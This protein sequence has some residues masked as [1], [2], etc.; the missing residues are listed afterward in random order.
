MFHM[1]CLVSPP[2]L[3]LPWVLSHCRLP[4][5]CCC[6]SFQVNV[7]EAHN[8]KRPKLTAFYEKQNSIIE[9]LME[10]EALHRGDYEGDK[11]DEDEA[12][13]TQRQLN[14]SFASNIALL[15]IRISVALLSGSLSLLVTTLDAVL[16]V[17]SGAII[18]FTSRTSK[19]QDKYNY[20]IGKTRMAPLGVVVFSSIMGTAGLSIIVEG[21][22]Q[23]I[24]HHGADTAAAPLVA[25]IASSIGII[26][27]KGIMWLICRKSKNPSV[28]AF[29][30]DHLNDVVVNSA[31]LGGA[32]LGKFV[33]WWLDPACAIVMSAWL[34]WAWGGQAYEQLVSLVG[35]SA[36]PELLQKLTYVAF[37]HAPEEIKQI[38][39][40]RA[41]SYGPD[42]WL[43]EIDI[44]LP[45]DMPLAQ[46]HDV[47]EALQVKLERL[48][49]VARA[50][51]HLDYESAH[52]PGI[53]HKEL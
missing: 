25:I 9:G 1:L 39:T 27:M 22:T 21:I 18:W 5:M 14:I 17:I 36:P 50:F 34:I 2:P 30:L 20:P 38:D 41:Y 4:D 29:A 6:C 49:E 51:V 15:L 23:I 11:E 13:R 31:G 19:K 24:G 16:D 10:A 8:R 37:Q 7:S 32:L 28:Q 48:P 44:V 43:V 45:A 12:A 52:S 46:A 40:V 42:Q 26:V 33:H 47:G 3:P 53:E 35:R